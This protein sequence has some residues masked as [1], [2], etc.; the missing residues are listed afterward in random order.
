[1]AFALTLDQMVTETRR[2]VGKTDPTKG[3][4]DDTGYKRLINQSALDLCIDSESLR[5]VKY[6]STK[7][8]DRYLPLDREIIWPIQVT[9][10]PLQGSMYPLDL[11][12]AA[13]PQMLVGNPTM[14]WPTAV[15]VPDPTGPSTRAIGVHPQTSYLGV[16]NV[17]VECFQVP[18]ELTSGTSVSEIMDAFHQSVCAR[19]ALLVIPPYKDKQY[20]V[21]ILTAEYRRGVERFKA[22]GNMAKKMEPK[23]GD[24]MLYGN[25]IRSRLG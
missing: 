8:N 25:M 14:W 15:N 23:S 18:V 24:V 13:P 5:T 2:L 1:M 19:A 21:P 10:I 6:L 7:A 22:V 9:F 4:L 16:S 12:H 20:L 11:V 17:K 3:G